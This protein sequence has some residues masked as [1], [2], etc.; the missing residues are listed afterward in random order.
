MRICLQ[1]IYISYLLF[2]KKLLF[3]K[4]VSYEENE[5]TFVG[6][7][8]LKRGKEKDNVFERHWK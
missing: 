6:K 8:I 7:Y 3:V 4:E 5:I 2:A 1:Y